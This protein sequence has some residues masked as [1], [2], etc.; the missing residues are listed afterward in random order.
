MRFTRLLL[1]VG[2][3]YSNARIL[4]GIE[5]G[6]SKKEIHSAYL[7]MA[8]QYHPDRAQT[9]DPAEA[10]ARFQEI[11]DAYQLLIG[12]SEANQ[13]LGYIYFQF[14]KILTWHL[15]EST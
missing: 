1:D 5:S 8:K 4:L 10:E 7:K 6:A 12:K 3:K 9:A 2:K 15:I 14:T 11:G 13:G